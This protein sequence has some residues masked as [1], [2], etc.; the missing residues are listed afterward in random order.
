[1]KIKEAKHKFW[2]RFLFALLPLFIGAIGIKKDIITN[3]NW[4]WPCLIL[5]LVLYWKLDSS[6]ELHE[7]R[8]KLK[9]L[10]FLGMRRELPLAK[11]LTVDAVSNSGNYI[12][13]IGFDP[14][15]VRSAFWQG[16]DNLLVLSPV[17]FT[18]TEDFIR[19]IIR[20]NP[21]ITVESSALELLDG[22]KKV[23]KHIAELIFGGLLLIILV[24]ILLMLRGKC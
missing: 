22:K 13:R 4:L 12:Y 15:I 9:G 14:S 23:S 3:I 18:N 1:M 6:I 21:N 11:I 19:E 10:M 7:D 8:L 16:T 20:T 17:F 2:P 24:G 5:C